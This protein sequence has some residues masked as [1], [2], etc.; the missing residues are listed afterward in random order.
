MFKRVFFGVK[1]AFCG[2]FTLVLVFAGG[3]GFGYPLPFYMKRYVAD[4]GWIMSLMMDNFRFEPAGFDMSKPFSKGGLLSL[5]SAAQVYGQS[6]Y[7]IQSGVVDHGVELS[8]LAD[9]SDGSTTA[10]Q[11][12][13]SPTAQ[14]SGTVG[15]A[16]N[17]GVSIPIN[18]PGITLNPNGQIGGHAD[19]TWPPSVGVNGNAG[20]GATIPIFP[21]IG[22]TPTGQFSVNGNVTP[23]LGVS[24]SII[25]SV[26]VHVKPGVRQ[27]VSLAKKNMQTTAAIVDDQQVNV[28]IDNCLG[29]ASLRMYTMLKIS[30]PRA[31]TTVYLYSRKID[32]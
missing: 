1:L 13:I 21:A 23:T 25:P 4:D 32:L 31:D 24:A 8:C 27:M 17:V 10:L 19:L 3:S 6:P 30:S 20:I 16:T 2:F 26:S 7:P 5:K 11:G 9:V 29:P 28:M 12:V 22:V 15:T 18:Y 14:I